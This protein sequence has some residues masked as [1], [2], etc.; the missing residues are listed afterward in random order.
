[1]EYDRSDAL[2]K[3][4]LPTGNSPYPFPPAT[5]VKEAR[6]EIHHVGFLSEYRGQ[7]RPDDHMRHAV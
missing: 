7:N 4:S 3:H 5:V 2:S 6:V 1:M